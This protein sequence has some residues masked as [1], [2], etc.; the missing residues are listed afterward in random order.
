MTS[1]FWA[2]L[3]TG[4]MLVETV[5][6]VVRGRT[7]L[8]SSTLKWDVLLDVGQSTPNHKIY[9]SGQAN[10]LAS[11]LIRMSKV[12]PRAAVLGCRAQKAPEKL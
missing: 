11:A 6:D 1:A 9:S 12:V 3:G 5:L 2:W 8:R 10:V 4:S 7:S